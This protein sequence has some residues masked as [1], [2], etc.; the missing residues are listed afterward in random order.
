MKKEEK[1]THGD[2]VQKV[3]DAST[4]RAVFVIRL[5][6]LGFQ[7]N[8]IDSNRQST[9]ELHAQFNLTNDQKERI[10]IPAGMS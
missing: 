5:K 6:A 10:T 8:P 3:N 1:G 2:L 4:T 9:L 7:V